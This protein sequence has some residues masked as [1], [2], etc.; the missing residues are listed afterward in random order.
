MT[1][2]TA[3]A[4]A[5][6]PT[7]MKLGSLIW[8]GYGPLYVA[9]ALDLYKKYNLKISLQIFSDPALLPPAVTSGAVDGATLTYDQVVGQVGNGK[10]MKVVMPI[11]YS[12]GGDA[13]LADM[14]I[15]SVADFKGKK[16]GYAPLSPSDFLL[17]YALSKNGM[18]EK[19]VM[20]VNVTPETVPAAMASGQMK[21]GVTYEPSVSQTLSQGGGKKFKVI[22]SSKDA[23]GL[24]GDALVFDEKMIQSKPGEITGIIK[25]YLD[26]L[27]YMKARP[28]ESAKI[29]GKYMGISPKE[30]NEQLKGVYFF[31]AAEMAKVFTRSADTT[32]YY[33]TSQIIGQLL[34]QK[35]EA[36]QVPVAEA[37]F[38]PQFINAINK[39]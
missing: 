37:T 2:L 10:K 26:G 7:P 25:A 6:S 33:A 32:S 8:I 27:S 20:P 35:G 13:I 36:R 28:E 23:P 29:I 24:L 9:E 15:K 18:S 3:S 5:A 11:D 14:S 19:D 34:K 21:I 22:Y 12:S 16:V 17:T 39:K 1:M 4:L 31:S 30:V 38:D